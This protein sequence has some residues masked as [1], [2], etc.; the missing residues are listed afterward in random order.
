[1]ISFQGPTTFFFPLSCCR[2]VADET[3]LFCHF[4][5]PPPLPVESK[6]VG[7]RIPEETS[8]D[9]EKKMSPLPPAL[10]C[11]LL[12]LLAMSEAKTTGRQTGSPSGVGGPSQGC[13]GSLRFH[14]LD[15]D[16]EGGVRILKA[17]GSQAGRSNFARILRG[18][19]LFTFYIY[20]SFCYVYCSFRTDS[21][22]LLRVQVRGDCCWD[23]FPLYFFRGRRATL[24]PG[25]DGAPEPGIRFRSLRRRDCE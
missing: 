24:K 17:T 1:M 18:F 4:R 10:A 5:L 14:V 21:S 13:R 15:P 6:A 16:R 20:S 22:Q 9:R 11:A 8:P 19:A 25:F 12:L 23:A 2:L 3:N 7:R